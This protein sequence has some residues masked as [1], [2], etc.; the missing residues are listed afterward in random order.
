MTKSEFLSKL[1]EALENDLDGA[2]VRE[3]LNYYSAYIDGEIRN[4]RSEAEVLAELGDP[5]VI[6]Q[7]VIGMSERKAGAEEYYSDYRSNSRSTGNDSAY[8][9]GESHV[10]TY[11]MDK[12]WQKLLWS[13]GKVGVVLL[14][15]GLVVGIFTLIGGIISFFMPVIL[16]VVVV[17]LAVKLIHRR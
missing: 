17:T 13:L 1:Q 3:N 14:I 6:A 2:G 5:W 12:W 9:Y 4:G 10:R 15:I 11:S 8:S 16:L 7:S